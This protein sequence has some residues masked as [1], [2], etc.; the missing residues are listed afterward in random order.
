MAGE[1]AWRICVHEASHA[2]AA[3]LTGL[4]CGRAYG[5]V[6]PDL[7]G[8]TAMGRT[9]DEALANAASAAVAWAEVA[10]ADGYAIP[11]PRPLEDLRADAGV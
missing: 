4:P 2:V 8:C 1:R 9:V 6:I 7:P 3:R 5:V 10:R 11:K